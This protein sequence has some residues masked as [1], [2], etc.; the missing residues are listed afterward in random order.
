MKPMIFDK[1]D[2]TT[3]CKRYVRNKVYTGKA[4]CHPNDYDFE[5]KLVGENYAYSRSLIAELCDDRDAK[6][7]QLKV[8]RHVYS[9]LE[10]N[11]KCDINS[12]EA[13][14]VRRQIAVTE[15]DLKSTREL[16]RLM[17][18]EL[19]NTIAGRDKMYARLREIR[20]TQG[21]SH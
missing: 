18:L 10:Q 19:R 6:L 21:I 2:H 17:R 5:S 16:I 14:I 4:T 13:Y 1:I 15:R 9:I 3:I 8:L 7:E 20:K 11:N 12:E